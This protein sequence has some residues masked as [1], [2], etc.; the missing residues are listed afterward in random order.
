[1]KRLPLFLALVATLGSTRLL[2]AQVAGVPVRTV[3]I[4]TGLSVGFDV[5]IAKLDAAGVV[6]RQTILTPSATVALG[7]GPLGLSASASRFGLDRTDR[8]TAHNFSIGASGQMTVIGGP[9]VPLSVVMQLGVTRF[10]QQAAAGS[11]G[12]QSADEDPIW[13]GHLGLG[14]SLAIPNPL[15]SIK[16]WIAPR[17]EYLGKRVPGLKR[18]RGALSAGIDLGVLNGLGLR[19]AYDSRTITDDATI[20]PSSISLG[21]SY[22]FR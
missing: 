16:P 4:P 12:G 15:F 11:T 14:A 19:A 22:S 20:D 7:L 21:L 13:R 6:E 9:L 5:G 18:F 2:H 10:P 17:I 3:G 8:T 1:M